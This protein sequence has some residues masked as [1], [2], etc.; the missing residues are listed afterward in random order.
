VS[1][2]A[3]LAAALLLITP[4]IGQDTAKVNPEWTAA[5]IDKVLAKAHASGSLVYRGQ[6]QDRGGTWDL[7]S[8]IRPK[9]A[10]VTAVQM[11]R[12]MFADDSHMQVTQDANGNIR[13]VE[14]EVPR[15]L[16][17]LRILQVSFSSGSYVFNNGNEALL[18]IMDAP[19]MRNYMIGEHIGPVMSSRYQLFI[20][21]S[22]PNAPK[23]SGDLYEVTVAEALDYIL[24]T[25]PG[26]W[27]YEECKGENGSRKVFFQ[28]FPAD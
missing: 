10:G 26:F 19:D 15:D 17:D 23:I 5:I 11:L 3:S 27:A 18:R 12:E 28:F 2:I 14:T 9:H 4:C 16:L 21:P 7:P 20:G 25:Y 1:Y 22:S 24:K 8:A 13:M 6:C